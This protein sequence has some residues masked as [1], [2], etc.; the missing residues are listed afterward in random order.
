MKTLPSL[1]YLLLIEDDSAVRHF[2]PPGGP[3]AS[4]K[5]SKAGPVVRL[6]LKLN[7]DAQPEAL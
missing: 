3:P 7:S 2:S 6:S 1:K 4:A 5:G